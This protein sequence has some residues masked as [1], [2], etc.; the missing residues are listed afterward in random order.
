MYFKLKD[1]EKKEL[2]ELM[3]VLKKEHSVL[4]KKDVDLLDDEKFRRDVGRLFIEFYGVY[5]HRYNPYSIAR[6]SRMYRTTEFEK[7]R[8]NNDL[9][10]E[11]EVRNYV[12]RCV[13]FSKIDF[14]REYPNYPV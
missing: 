3:D 12:K 6:T 9:A 8:K 2:R 1:A 14:E 4:E 13:A 7:A 5:Y 11:K 10:R